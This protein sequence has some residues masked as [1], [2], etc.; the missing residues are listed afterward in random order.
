MFLNFIYV[1]GSATDA[2]WVE[3][4]WR[5]FVDFLYVESTA[6]SR[7]KHSIKTRMYLHRLVYMLLTALMCILIYGG[8]YWLYQQNLTNPKTIENYFKTYLMAYDYNRYVGE[9]RYNAIQSAVF[10]T[11][12]EAAPTTGY[13]ASVPVLMYHRITAEGNDKYNVTPAA[14]KAQMFALKKAGYSTVSAEDYGDF[15]QGTKKLPAKSVLI[16]F[17]DGTKDSY[18]GA[19]PVLKALG[20]RATNF[21]ITR[22]SI[23]DPAGSHYYLSAIEL[24]AMERSG[25]WDLE[26]HTRDGHSYYQ[27]G[28]NGQQGEYYPNKLYLSTKHRMET[29]AEYAARVYN[30]MRTAKQEMQ[31]F[32][33]KPENLFAFPFS[34][35]G[36]NNSSNYSAAP[37]VLTKDVQKLF[38]N[39]MMLYYPGRDQ[40]Q[41]YYNSKQPL[42]YRIQLE[43]GKWMDGQGL[44]NFIQNGTAKPLPYTDD[45]QT[46]HGWQAAW[47]DSSVHNGTLTINGTKGSTGAGIILDGASG[48]SNYTL[49]ARATL[50]QGTSYGIIARMQGDA[51]RTGCYFGKGYVSIR[52][53]EGASMKTIA[54]QDTGLTILGQTHQV[55]VRVVGSQIACL[56]DGQTILQTT[57]KTMPATGSIGFSVWSANKPSLLN[58]TDVKVAKEK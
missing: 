1:E 26:V 7:P 6:R 16:T 22:Y 23:E 4:F 46:N 55:G 3:I 49:S 56:L 50:Q 54:E 40:S 39:A 28:A 21:I 5:S 9:S 47:G 48:W 17:D 37:T 15:I 30:D 45:L 14:F 24:K 51:Y 25:H 42:T 10:H 20:F 57:D 53:N 2:P 34:D 52:R 35:M 58:L 36:E 11:Q 18:Y 12:V 29:D 27:T 38:K 44:V 41:G 33:H 32:T 31:N 13:A 8:A 43:L 19:D